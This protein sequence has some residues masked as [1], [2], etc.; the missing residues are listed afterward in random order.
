MTTTLSHLRSPALEFEFY[1][2]APVWEHPATKR[3]LS[4]I[5]DLVEGA[6]ILG[7][8]RGVW[9]DVHES[10]NIVRV[11]VKRDDA[12]SADCIA[13]VEMETSRVMQEWSLSETTRQETLLYTVR[14]LTVHQAVYEIDGP[15]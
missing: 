14:E 7:G 5:Y 15:K 11:L 3:F 13:R 6:T 8:A 9:R 12:K 1:L 4:A 10:M 2:P